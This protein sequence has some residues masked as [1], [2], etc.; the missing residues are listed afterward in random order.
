MTAKY[1]YFAL[2]SIDLLSTVTSQQQITVPDFKQR[3]IVVPDRMTMDTFTKFIEPIFSKIKQ[4]KSEIQS[5]LG[6]QASFL[7][8]LS[9]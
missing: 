2:A 9:R 5:L 7:A 4:N 6:L 3:L 1:L 8:L